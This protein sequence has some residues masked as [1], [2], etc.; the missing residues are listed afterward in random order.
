M[1][2]VRHRANNVRFEASSVWSEASSVKR[3]A[4]N[5]RHKASSVRHRANNVRREASSVS[6]RA[7]SAKSNKSGMLDPSIPEQLD[8][9]KNCKTLKLLLFQRCDSQTLVKVKIPLTPFSGVKENQAQDLPYLTIPKHNSLNFQ[10]AISNITHATFVSVYAPT[11]AGAQADID[12]FYSQQRATLNNIP[13]M[14][15]IVV[16][17][18]LNARAESDHN[19]WNGVLGENGRGNLISI[20]KSLLQLCKEYSLS[21]INTFFDT[22]DKHFYSWKHPG[23]DTGIYLIIM[24]SQKTMKDVYHTRVMRA[25]DCFSDHHMIR[26]QIQLTIYKPKKIYPP[27]LYEFLTPKS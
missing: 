16:L 25:A 13:R 8:S 27:C 19:T 15:N 5:V 24:V 20:R 6:G 11:M 12:G 2:S 4:N 9:A 3:R 26:C 18:D 10:L 1:T 22:P 14:D 23:L 17:G 21:I 7:S